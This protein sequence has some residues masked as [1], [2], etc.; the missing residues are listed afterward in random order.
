VDIKSTIMFLRVFNRKAVVYLIL[1]PLA[2]TILFSVFINL[3]TTW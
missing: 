1:L 3:N 2:M